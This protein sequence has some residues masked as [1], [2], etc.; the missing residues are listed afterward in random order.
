MAEVQPDEPVVALC[1]AEMEARG[2]HRS[3]IGTLEMKLVDAL[4]GLGRA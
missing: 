4:H 1:M 2:M 3:A